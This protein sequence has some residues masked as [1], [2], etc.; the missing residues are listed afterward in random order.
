MNGRKPMP[1][2]S[3]W[4]LIFT[5]G[6]TTM[7][8][9]L[10]AA[11]YDPPALD[12]YNLHAE[13]DADGDGDGKEET[14][15][16]QFLNSH[17]DSIVSM[18]TGTQLWAWSLNTRGSESGESNYVIRDSDCDGQFDELYGLND[19]FHVPDCAK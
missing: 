17:G 9:Q 7:S 16:R 15:I 13:R 6:L 19:E 14:R 5:F 4:P 11:L 8:S 12:G 18:T 10:L 2:L 3:V 1:Y